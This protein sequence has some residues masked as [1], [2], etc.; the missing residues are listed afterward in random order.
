MQVALSMSIINSRTLCLEC[1]KSEFDP[2]NLS[3]WAQK[4]L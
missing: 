1:F 4:V 3:V 2:F